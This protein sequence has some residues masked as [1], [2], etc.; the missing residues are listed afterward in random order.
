MLNRRTVRFLLCVLTILAAFAVPA[1]SGDRIIPVCIEGNSTAQEVSDPAGR[2]LYTITVSWNTGVQQGVSHFD[3]ILGLSNCPCVCDRFPFDEGNGPNKSTGEDDCSVY[4][5]AS[6]ECKGDPSV[7]G[8]KGPLVKFEP[9]DA[10]KDCEPG[11]SGNGTFSFLS[12]WPPARLSTPND[13]LLIKFGRDS[14][15]GNL[16]GVLPACSCPNATQNSSW[17]DVKK[18]FR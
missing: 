14:C 10:G 5:S 18:M 16:T 2:W 11:N 13:L 7:D 15:R 1:H 17:G 8:E 6:F 4:Y 9:R 3:V 12:D